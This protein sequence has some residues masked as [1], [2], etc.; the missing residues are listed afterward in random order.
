MYRCSTTAL[1]PLQ[2]A[3]AASSSKSAPHPSR[4][5]RRSAPLAA[6]F[7][8]LHA[9]CVCAPL[10]RLATLRVRPTFS[11]RIRPSQARNRAPLHAY[12]VRS[13]RPPACLSAS[14]AGPALLH[15]CP[16][17]WPVLLTAAHALQPSSKTAAHHLQWPSMDNSI[18]DRSF[19]LPSVTAAATKPFMAGH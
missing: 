11:S 13:A 19:L 12:T 10:H 9:A 2:A 14:L 18:N 7:A 8:P 5:P 16:L 15:A 17:P 1:G 3:A 6:C 4:W